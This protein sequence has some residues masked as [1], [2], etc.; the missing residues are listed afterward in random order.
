MSRSSIKSDGFQAVMFA[1]ES[2]WVP[3]SKFPNL[4]GA[5]LLGIDTET[6][7]P[8]LIA[9]G[10]GSF[11]KDGELVGISL[12]DGERS[13]YF[14]IRHAGGGNLDSGA[15]AHYVGDLAKDETRQWVGA[16]VQYDMEW[17]HSMGIKLRGKVFDVQIAEALLDEEADTVELNYLSQKYCNVPKDETLL[18]QAARDF[19]VDPKGGLWK[20]PSKY[21]GP[22]AEWDACA[23]VRIF[24][25]QVEA[26]RAEDLLGIF[27][28]E[29]R[30]TPIL[31][32]MR[33]RGI[34]VDLEAAAQLS[35]SL[36]CKEDELRF[37][38]YRD[39]GCRID[40][41]SG[42][43]IAK[44]CDRMKIIYPRTP[45]G[46]PSFTGDWLED[47]DHPLIKS[48]A[49]LRE[50]NR[51]RQTFIDQWI[52]DHQIGGVIHPQWKQL[53]SDDGGTR[54]GRMAA[55]NPNPQQVPSRAEIAPLIRALF[56]P[57]DKS[58]KWNKNDYSQQEPRLLVHFAALC[59]MTGADL[60]K[61]AY[62]DNP[63]M[64]I[65][66]FLADSAQ[67]VRRQSKDLTLGRMYNMGRAKLAMKL[68]VSEDKAGEIL[69][70][71]DASVPFV[72]EISEKCMQLASSRGWVRTIGGRR[73]HFNFY[74]PA[75]WDE[76]KTGKMPLRLEQAKQM[77]P[78]K[79]LQRAYTHKA[80]NSL[81]QGSA[82]DMTK[83]AMVNI[84]EDRGWIPYM[85][86]HDELNYG[87]ENQEQADIVKRHCETAIRLEVPVR[88]DSSLGD[89]WK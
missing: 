11:R 26:M 79:R 61:M 22:Y 13:F 49:T 46:N 19:G 68:G 15:V 58:L 64:D 5:R 28:L 3:P 31:W 37:Q 52:F 14:P 2:S 89:H 67:V 47:H 17:L 86:V 84:Y 76:R 81:I 41:W 42:D 48:I 34:P 23:P 59:G 73:R 29:T 6:R 66:Q 56:V 54:T 88:V 69:A 20:L 45:K 60:A 82:A 39:H 85:Q 65:Y 72:K 21:V 38:L 44:M 55:S 12:S 24:E 36:K 53:K 25:K 18:R 83:T 57:H 10:P 30:L 9:K 33:K 43:M 35:D 78:R 80:L 77:W 63:D 7:D 75:D 74:E 50:L 87:V 51:L 32:E 8:Y 27:D 1:P 4:G 62:R 16:N 40:E 71:F 70:D